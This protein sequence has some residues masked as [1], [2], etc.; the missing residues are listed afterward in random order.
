[1][2]ALVGRDLG[3]D[4]HRVRFWLAEDA[5]SV[6]RT[7][8]H[9]QFGRLA[10]LVWLE[11]SRLGYSALAKPAS[12]GNVFSIRRRPGARDISNLAVQRRSVLSQRPRV[13]TSPIVNA[14]VK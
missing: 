1:M 14:S 12:F 13:L 5:H 11:V 6:P 9:G 4:K 7:S 2:Q 3:Q 8:R 10:H